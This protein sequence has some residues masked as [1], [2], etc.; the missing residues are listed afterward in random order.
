M[1]RPTINV[2][3]LWP[4]RI[5]TFEL[6]QDECADHNAELIRL[7]INASKI[8]TNPD[9][10]PNFE[11]R[12]HDLHKYASPSVAWLCEAIANACRHFIGLPT[13]KIDVG[14]RAVLL[15]YGMHINTHTE[16][17]ESDLMVAYWPGGSLQD[18]DSP[19]NRFAHRQ[20][21]PTFVVEDPSR[22][23][24]DLR[25]PGEIRHSIMIAPRPGLMVVG[26][27]HVPHNL[28]PYLG[29]DPFIHIVAHIKVQWPEG[30]DERW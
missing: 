26:P 3:S 12:V 5:A 7:V 19:I 23:L 27:A 6:P 16:S 1:S 18:M 8:N 29:D 30:Y 24:T 9:P 20:V 25:L 4:T 15:R 13:L 11:I 10:G 2:M 22:A 17:H 21:A 14:L 28:W